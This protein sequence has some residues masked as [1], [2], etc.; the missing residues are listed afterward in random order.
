LTLEQRDGRWVGQFDLALVQ[1]DEKG[2]ESEVRLQS[3]PLNLAPDAHEGVM[4]QGVV[5]NKTIQRN[6]AATALRVVV[7]D[8]PSGSLG[9]V[10]IPLRKQ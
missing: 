7:R 2:G 10:I 4:T 8:A 6:K 5:V 3:V 1:T 9:R